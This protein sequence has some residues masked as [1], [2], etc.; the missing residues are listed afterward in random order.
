MTKFIFLAAAFVACSDSPM[1]PPTAPESPSPSVGYVRGELLMS[2]NNQR[3]KCDGTKF[4]ECIRDKGNWDR[5]YE[6]NDNPFCL[7]LDNRRADCFKIPVNVGDQV[8][9][10]DELGRFEAGPFPLGVP[11][12]V[13]IDERHLTRIVVEE[14]GRSNCINF[15]EDGGCSSSIGPRNNGSGSLIDF[16]FETSFVL[17]VLENSFQELRIAKTI[18]VVHVFVK[19]DDWR[20]TELRFWSKYHSSLSDCETLS[21]PG[22]YEITHPGK[23]QWN[24]LMYRFTN[25]TRREIIFR[26]D[27]CL[28]N[29]SNFNVN[30]DAF[31]LQTIDSTGYDVCR[32]IHLVRPSSHNVFS[33][34][35]SPERNGPYVSTGRNSCER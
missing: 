15:S 29:R 22:D 21:W 8:V 18:P 13:S 27:D 26:G 34:R 11:V 1:G 24:K 23:T 32:Q 5:I 14:N 17:P 6:I 31:I 3:L 28:F 2:E 16:S 7:T 20:Q 10:T 12:E 25:L 4:F 9:Y 30:D 33:A 19:R 35:R